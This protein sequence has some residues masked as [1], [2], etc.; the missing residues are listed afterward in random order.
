MPTPL[1]APLQAFL[2][3]LER[4]RKLL[5]MLQSI[6]GFAAQ[7]ATGADPEY[8]FVV[9]S[10]EVRDVVRLRSAELPILS[11]TL[12][13]YL[14]GRFENFAR[15]SFELLCDLMAE[16]CSRLADL[17]LKMRTELVRLTAE[18]VAAPA[19]YS[20]DEI[21]VQAF[22]TTLAGNM[23]ASS[24]LGKVNSRCLSVTSVN[25]GARMVAE[26]FKRAGID[27]LWQDIGR[28]AP[29]RA[30]LGIEQDSQATAEVQTRLDQLMKLRNGIAHP[31]SDTSF[32][33]LD[34]VLSYVEFLKHISTTLVS[35]VEMNL[36]VFRP[37]D[38]ALAGPGS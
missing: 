31:T 2:E 3:D 7:D 30:W 6:R 14:A 34:Q 33:D 25:M 11:G 27:H 22:V 9:A 26:L 1:A 5:E 29:L 19:K 24:G 16:R 12:L 35:V 38:A 17:P 36:A 28:Q 20:F 23:T 21:E 15:D 4:V 13:L 37:S 8:G 10:L 18:A 32:P